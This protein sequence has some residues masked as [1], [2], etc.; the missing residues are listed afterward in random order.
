MHDGF[1]VRF[2]LRPSPENDVMICLYE[3]MFLSFP[4]Y[5]H[6]YTKSCIWEVIIKLFHRKKL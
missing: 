3:I 4:Q 6:G 1:L 5:H 2:A